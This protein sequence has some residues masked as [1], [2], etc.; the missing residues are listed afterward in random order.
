M[1]KRLRKMRE[2]YNTFLIPKKTFKRPEQVE[3]LVYD[4]EGS[5]SLTPFIEKYRYGILKLRGEEINLYC[6]CKCFFKKEFWLRSSFETYIF[7]YINTVRPAVVI[8]FIDNDFRFYKIS[9]N[10][11]STK[12]IFIQNGRR[13]K[14][15]DI[16][17]YIEKNNDY[18][19]DY[20]LV[21]GEAVGRKYREFIEGD[22]LPIGS[23]R[24]NNV[25]NSESVDKNKIL[26]VSSWSDKPTGGSSFRTLEDGM[27]VSWEDYFDVEKKVLKF[28]DS[29]CSSNKKVLQIC[30]RNSGSLSGEKAFY[31]EMLHSCEWE[32]L[33]RY[34]E[35]S[36]YDYLSKSNMVVFIDSTVGYESL[37]RGKRT[38]ALVCRVIGKPDK[39]ESFGWP[40]VLSE[41]GSFWSNECSDKEFERIMNYLTLVGDE[42]WKAEYQRYIPQIMVFDEGNKRLDELIHK[43]LSPKD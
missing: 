22:V 14:I 15:H 10:C 39:S 43:L 27:K 37:S 36:T 7:S 6:L 19:V 34:G 24:N 42:E 41:K 3:V 5:E 17:G 11:P 8:T 4:Q 28:L 32:F 16:F 20:M 29:W 21:A 12:T 31:A 2:F 23:L 26:F 1:L 40:A 35:A 30:A 38:A 18:K 25:S 13:A 9:K 33:A